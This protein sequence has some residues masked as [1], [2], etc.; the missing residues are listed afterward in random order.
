[1]LVYRKLHGFMVLTLQADADDIWDSFVNISRQP[2]PH[3]LFFLK[4]K[5]VDDT[6]KDNCVHRSLNLCSHNTTPDTNS[7][8]RF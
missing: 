3:C 1:M 4:R 5:I 7:A 2:S 8:T 6:E